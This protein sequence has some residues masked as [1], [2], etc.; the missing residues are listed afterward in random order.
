MLRVRLHHVGPSLFHRILVS[1]FQLGKDLQGIPEQCSLRSFGDSPALTGAFGPFF[2]APTTASGSNK[3][4]NSVGDIKIE[5]NLSPRKHQHIVSVDCHF[6]FPSWRTA[7]QMMITTVMRMPPSDSRSR[8]HGWKDRCQYCYA[9]ARKIHT[10]FF[11]S[12]KPKTR[13]S[14]FRAGAALSWSCQNLVTR[15]DVEWFEFSLSAL[16]NAPIDM[17]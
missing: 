4:T 9:M 12:E 1:D 17:C 15:Q 14:S 8:Q 6:R 5:L 7:L 3:R 11:L 10:P 16:G 13:V 2:A